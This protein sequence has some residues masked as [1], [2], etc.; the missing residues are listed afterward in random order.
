MLG[1]DINGHPG[2]HRDSALTIAAERGSEDDVLNLIKAGTDANS[3]EG[4][5]GI[6]HH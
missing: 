3:T 4:Y 5:F 6:K 1:A 2:I